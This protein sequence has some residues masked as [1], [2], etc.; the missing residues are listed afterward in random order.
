MAVD[1]LCND[2]TCAKPHALVSLRISR[3][4]EAS[5]ATRRQENHAVPF[6]EGLGY[7]VVGIAED[8]DVSGAVPVFER[9]ALGEWLREHS[10]RFNAIFFHKLDRITRNLF[11][12]V[13]MLRWARENR[14]SLMCKE[15]LMD[16]TSKEGQLIGMILAHFA[17]Q[18]RQV[19]KER[20]LDARAANL[21]EGKYVGGRH[22]W[23]T[24]RKKIKGGP[25]WRLK[26]NPARVKL[27]RR[28]I[29]MVLAQRSWTEIRDWLIAEGVPCPKGARDGKTGERPPGDMGGI[30]RLSSI[31]ALVTNPAL[32]GY[33]ETTI[34]GEGG[35]RAMDLVRVDGRP[36]K[37]MDAI[38]SPMEWRAIQAE[39]A[40]RLKADTKQTR[41]DSPGRG[42]F[43]CLLC[44]RNLSFSTS[45][46]K[47]KRYSYYRCITRNTP[48]ACGHKLVAPALIYASVET[49]LIAERASQAIYRKVEGRKV[50][51]SAQLWALEES[52]RNIADRLARMTSRTIIE[53]LEAQLVAI[54]A[55]IQ[56]LTQ[57]S[58]EPDRTEYIPTGDTLGELWG[59]LDDAG[60]G[61]LLREL[62]VIVRCSGRVV[63]VIAPEDIDSRLT[64]ITAGRVVAP[65]IHTFPHPDTAYLA[66]PETALSATETA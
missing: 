18:E 45:T 32:L 21:A 50:D 1:I 39:V 56:E 2:P 24:D 19:M 6:A 43:K 14:I 44:G 54:D 55:E 30:W 63:H 42:V 15:P 48:V 20:A 25:G 65:V 12:F 31:K 26:L 52:A 16:F 40:R 8:L 3:L 37:F 11:D 27:M 34:R 33:R 58:A 7:C 53:H 23:W 9:P 22:P 41:R 28:I 5:T 59:R 10:S 38:V 64:D 60:K 66:A 51:Y 62:G 47:G 35:E 57:L 13:D 4:T 29:E 61:D 17:D 36:V 49:E 46:R